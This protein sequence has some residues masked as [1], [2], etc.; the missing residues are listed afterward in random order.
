MVLD[1]NLEIVNIMTGNGSPGADVEGENSICW[2]ALRQSGQDLNGSL[3][4]VY[5]MPLF[6]FHVVA[7]TNANQ[8]TI[9]EWAHILAYFM[10]SY[11]NPHILINGQEPGYNF[12]RA[13]LMLPPAGG[14]DIIVGGA[15]YYTGR[16]SAGR[17]V[18]GDPLG[19]FGF[20]SWSTVPGNFF[21][22]DMA[23]LGI[24]FA[25]TEDAINE[26]LANGFSPLFL[27]HYIPGSIVS[28][29]LLMAMPLLS[30]VPTNEYDIKNCVGNAEIVGSGGGPETTQHVYWTEEQP[31]VFW[32]AEPLVDGPGIAREGFPRLCIPFGLPRAEIYDDPGDEA[33]LLP[34]VY[35]DFSD[36]SGTRGP[37]PAT[38][39]GRG[40]ADENGQYPGPF[41]FC[42]AFHP[43]ISIDAVYIDDVLQVDGFTVN[44]SNNFQNKSTIA[45]IT[46]EVM[47]IGQVTW[48]GLGLYDATG[49]ALMENAVDQVVHLLTTWGNFDREDDFDPTA[50]ATARAKIEELGYQT[51]F[52]VYDERVTQDWLTEM[53]FN[54][55]GYWRIDGRERIQFF[56]DDGGL[57]FTA[58][59]MAASIVPSRDCRDGDEGVEMTFDRRYL[60]NQIIPYFRWSYSTE[61]PTIRL[62]D[63]RD[64]AMVEAYGES[65][66]EVTLKGLRRPEDVEQWASVLL[67]RQSGRTR[68]EGATFAGELI[69]P[70]FAHLSIGDL[71]A[72]SW[73]FGPRR[74]QGNSMINE[75]FRLVSFDLDSDRGGSFRFTA[76]ALG[77]YIADGSGQRILSPIE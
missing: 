65:R 19:Q 14:W 7:R 33:A 51:A 9:G 6:G 40:E 54:V 76:V 41:T 17:V 34:I 27:Q 3:L 20:P 2:L 61:Q 63:Q 18:W 67:T 44:T 75:V 77:A 11:D 74:E 21:K 31:A 73:P 68:I 5:A 69:H 36:T 30:D 43:V 29:G 48:R 15:A 58:S 10:P 4:L 70:R 53:L 32:P 47:P 1:E 55:M 60:V 26:S 38:L 46:F 66:K 28:P 39:I 62:S 50:L 52:V 37:I 57:T 45:T 42:A 25:S 64:A 35:G 49:D 8:L 24:F 59:E 56:A 23:N 71:V 13:D 72:I 12:T 16:I 22:G